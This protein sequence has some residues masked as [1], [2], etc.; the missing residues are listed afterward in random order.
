MIYDI[1]PRVIK[2]DVNDKESVISEQESVIFKNL[3]L[4][5]SKETLHLS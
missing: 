2:S 5:G 1:L 3:G 4:R